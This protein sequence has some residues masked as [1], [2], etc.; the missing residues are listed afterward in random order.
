M[1]ESIEISNCISIGIQCTSTLPLVARRLGNEERTFRC[2]SRFCLVDSFDLNLK[3]KKILCTMTRIFINIKAAA[4]ETLLFGPHTSS[5][6]RPL[7]TNDD[8][9][10]Q[11][12]GPSERRW[13]ETKSRTRE[14]QR[15]ENNGNDGR[16]QHSLWKLRYCYDTIFL[17]GGS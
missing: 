1:Y 8:E 3:K 5:L 2:D 17:L 7:L 12:S 16:L 4:L 10:T 15:F 14:S 13:K 6:T 9:E 11:S